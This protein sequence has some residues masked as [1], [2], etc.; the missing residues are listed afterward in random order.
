M[1]INPNGRLAI[2]ANTNGI[3]YG[4]RIVEEINAL[5]KTDFEEGKIKLKVPRVDV[6]PN[7]M[8][9]VTLDETVR[10]EDAFLVQWFP[11]PP[12]EHTSEL[13]APR[14][15]EEF[16]QS[17]AA[18]FQAGVNRLTFVT[19]YVYD[20]RKDTL[21][22]RDTIGAALFCQELS[23]IT[24]RERMQALCLD[25]HAQQLV[26]LY[27]MININMISVPMFSTYVSYVKEEHPETLKNAVLVLPDEGSAK[28]ARP[29]VKLTGLDK[30]MVVKKRIS[31]T[32]SIPETYSA[33]GVEIKGKKGILV[34]DILASGKT[35]ANPSRH[36]LEKGMSELYWWMTH[37][38]VTNI[39]QLDTF[40]KEKL[41]KKIF[42]ADT[43][44]LPDRDY[45]FSV[46]TA[47]IMARII[48]NIHM[49]RSIREY[50]EVEK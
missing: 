28:R 49:N 42:L 21:E 8:L 17:I 47:K 30:I 38:E 16:F 39:E 41:F 23:G 15:K 24:N 36:L 13:T 10:G 26:G 46:P 2:Y 6:F 7:S 29:F 1:H 43:I 27:Q 45:F 12:G 14:N 19:P 5:L 50:L 31:P 34:D 40:Y 3:F 35:A 44:Q 20:Q 9:K 11:R 22:G 48:Y 25:I 32:E 18:L 33:E 37:P 4:Q